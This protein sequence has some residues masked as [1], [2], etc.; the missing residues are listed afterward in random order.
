[1]GEPKT[2][3]VLV[4][5][6]Q[7]ACQASGVIGGHVGCTGLS[8][9]GR[10]QAD[11][12]RKRLSATGEL[13]DVGSMATSVLPRAIE[14]AERIGPEVGGG[15]VATEQDCEWCELHPGEGDGLHWEEFA[16]RYGTSSIDADPHRSL[17]PGGESWA[18]MVER[19]RARLG[20]L[21][22]D[23]RGERTVVVCHGGVIIA[24]MVS[25]LGLALND[26]WRGLE[27]TNTSLTEWE[28]RAGRWRL[29]RYNDHAHLGGWS[30]AGG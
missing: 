17:A 4:R 7:S 3:V 24:S 21:V 10:A 26:Q 19:V 1:M 15:L 20:K 29:V 25:L 22:A 9:L 18:E 30:A 14:T 23:R 27:P 11:T 13:S 28:H 6:G 2:R 12:L 8:E 16:R 5:H